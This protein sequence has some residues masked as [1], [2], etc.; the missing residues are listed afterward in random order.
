MNN[1]LLASALMALIGGYAGM[2]AANVKVTMNNVSKTMTLASATTGETVDVGALSGTDYTFEV[3]AGEYVLTGIATD[4]KTINGTINLTVEDKA[5]TQEFKIITVT[6]YATNDKNTWS[7]ENGDY[8]LDVKVNSREGKAFQVTTGNSTTAGRYTFLAYNG[9]SYYASFVPAQKWVAEGYT[10]LYR[11]G[12]LTANISVSGAIPKGENYTVTVPSEAEF[13]LGMKFAHFVD[14]TPVAPI[15]DERDGSNR[16]LTYYLAQGQ[17]YNYRT[18]MEGKITRAGYFTMAADAEKRPVLEFAAADYD[19]DPATVNHDPKSNGGYEVGDILNNINEKGHLTLAQGDTY[20]LHSMRAW[21][22]TDSSSGNYFMEPDFHYTVV[23]LDGK[24]AE[25]VVEI[26]AKPGSAW[27]DMKAIGQGEVIVL[28]TYDALCTNYYSNAEKKPFM[29]GELWSAIWPENTAAFVVSVGGAKSTAVPNMVVNE[30]Y[31]MNTLRLAGNNID[32]EHDVFYYLDTEEGARYTFKPENVSE[33]LMAYP[34]IGE[35]MASYHGFGSEGVTRNEDGSY[36]LL[37]KH[38]RQIV[39]LIDNAGNAVY[40]V[41]TAKECHRD[42]INASRPGSNIFQPGDEVKIQYSGLF[43]PASKM[44]G[45]YNMSAYVTY[46]GVPN[47]TSLILGAGQYTFAS[48]PSAQAVTLAIPADHDIAAKPQIVMDRGVIQVNGF[49]DP[50]GNHRNIDDVAG[51]SPNFTAIAHKTYFGALPEV[52]LSLTPVKNFD[53]KTVCNVEDAE[54]ELSFNGK[55]LAAGE[56]GLYSGTYGT[57][58]VVAV[59]DG[60]RCFRASYLIDDDAD[61]LQ[62]FNIDLEESNGAWDGK[63]KTEPQLSDGVYVVTDGNELAWIADKVNT[64]GTA[65]DAVIVADIDLGNFDWTPIGES[66]SKAFA[67]TV[68]GENHTVTGLFIDNEKAQYKG[69]FGYVKGTADRRA[70]ISGINI[71]GEVSAK[72]YA[73]GIAG[74]LGAYADIDRCSNSA[75][76]TGASTNIGGIAGYV[77]D[78]TAK[79]TNCYNTGVITGTGSCGGIVGGHGTKGVVVENAFNIGKIDCP[80]NAGACVGSSYKKDGLVNVFAIEE[81]DKT[82]GHTLVT[83]EQIKSGEVAYRLGAAFGQEIGYDEHPVFGGTE[84]KYDPDTDTYYNYDLPTSVDE[85]GTE[86]V[87]E[88]YYNVEGIP[89]AHPYKGINIVRMSDGTVRKVIIR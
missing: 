73:G 86:A 29:G 13:Q 75:D 14:F 81:Y 65:I 88:T 7:V 33:V 89:S 69:L 58:N 15:A 25:G 34:E 52:V 10:T 16:R 49:G 21:E 22:I 39:K 26:T 44:A 61:G 3:P 64:D 50:I 84:V 48:V 1:K 42:I 40:Q 62:T 80:K 36:T 4:G 51:R 45:I 41:V 77:F 27:A 83:P 72:S 32:A 37:L 66:S 8:T 54:I 87:P 60:Y 71:E 6:A 12:T 43:H 19:I 56:N 55:P 47:G 38:G 23:G 74:Y 59:K 63:S 82:D 31:N 85:I 70:S 5:D 79:I 46:N 78:N 67:G 35:R 2:D 53:I 30:D 28:V 24:P 20:K 11:S 68:N 17:I 18:W 76:I 9:N 57:Y